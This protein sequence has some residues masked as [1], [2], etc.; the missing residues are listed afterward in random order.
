KF[1]EAVDGCF[2]QGFREIGG[3]QY[4][5][6]SIPGYA[7]MDRR[8]VDWADAVCRA[9]EFRSGT[10]HLEGMLTSN[11]IELVELNPRPGGSEVVRIVEAVSGVNL[12][13]ETPRLWLEAPPTQFPATTATHSTL[14][15]IVYPP[16]PAKIRAIEPEK[17]VEMNLLGASEAR[18]LPE[19]S[20][21]AGSSVGEAK[22]EEYLGEVH[23]PNY[24]PTDTAA[25]R[26]DVERLAKWAMDG[27]LIDF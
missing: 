25:L 4:R 27:H 10:F 17:H 12:S 1:H 20:L 8:I 14:Y 16:G 11:A 24:T 13:R 5:P 3:M 19:K 2:K 9:L 7:D 15:T 26:L 23:V 21:Q 6:F 18:W 22:G